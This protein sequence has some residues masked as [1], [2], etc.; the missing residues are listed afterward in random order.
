MKR[1]YQPSKTRRNRTHGFLV[2]MKSR[3]GRS[4]I[5]ASRLCGGANYIGR[6]ELRLRSR[7]FILLSRESSTQISRIGV[8]FSK[9]YVPLSVVRSSVRRQVKELFRKSREQIKSRDVV[10]RATQKILKTDL[11][12]AKEELKQLWERVLR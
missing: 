10:V 8:S 1:T 2:R 4:V 9:R 3:G 6:F 7:H 12:D 5:N 11:K